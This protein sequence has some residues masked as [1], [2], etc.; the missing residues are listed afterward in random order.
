MIKY[1]Y[2]ISKLWRLKM[3]LFTSILIITLAISTLAIAE[4]PVLTIDSVEG[5]KGILTINYTVVDTS[6]VEFVT[7]DWQFS[8]D[9]GS[10]WLDI[11]AAAIGNNTSKPTG[12]SFITMELMSTVS[13]E[14]V[15]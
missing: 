10:T 12:S 15:W 3:K 14:D 13:S 9:G 8:T 4:P 6:D 5:N 1:P 11:D 2:K 7:D